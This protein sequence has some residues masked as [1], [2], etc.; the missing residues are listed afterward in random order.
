MKFLFQLNIIFLCNHLVVVVNLRPHLSPL[1]QLQLHVSRNLIKTPEVILCGLLVGSI[2]LSIRGH[3]IR[4]GRMAVRS[5]RQ[6]I[7][8]G[9]FASTK[10]Q[11]PGGLWFPW[12][13]QLACIPL[14]IIEPLHIQGI[15]DLRLNQVPM[16]TVV[17]SGSRWKPWR[18]WLDWFPVKLF[19]GSIGST[20]HVNFLVRPRLPG[21]T[22]LHMVRLELLAHEW[23][24]MD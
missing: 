23:K 15:I 13:K 8:L 7:P 6:V 4:T 18:E 5:G 24:R 16:D 3:G 17:N 21:I 10:L 14:W 1:N 20:C 2:P 12:T 22:G 9:S 19:S 11:R